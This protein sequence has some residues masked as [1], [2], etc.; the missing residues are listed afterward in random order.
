M[1]S[2]KTYTINNTKIRLVF[3]DILTSVT[4][5]LVISGSLGIPMKGGL[6][7][8]TLKRSGE[9]VLIDTAKFSNAKLGDVVVTSAGNLPHKYL[10]QAVT[11][12]GWQ[13]VF[14]HL[15]DAEN[16][17][18]HEYIIEHCIQNSLQLLSAMDLRSIA[19]P[20]LG[21]G[22]GN[23]S[24]NGVA[25]TMANVICQF[26]SKTNKSHE[27]Y[28]YI[29]DTYGVYEQ[30]N[31]LPFFEWFAAYVHEVETQY[32]KIDMKPDFEITAL[33]KIEIRDISSSTFTHRLFISYSRKDSDQAKGVCQ[34]LNSMGIDYWI[35]INGIYSGANFKE[36]IVRAIETSE[37]V[38]F[39]SSANSNTSPNV[40]K[41][42]ALA[43]KF[44]KVIIPV[45]LD[46]A[47]LNRQINYDLSTIDFVDLFTFDENSVSKLKKSI[48]GNLA[49][50]GIQQS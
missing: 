25:K 33:D 45:R 26:A 5:I 37:V 15:T 23:M 34:I 3:G 9:T 19:F 31:Y 43:D 40:A 4:D 17:E 12:S 29:K 10:F 50:N 11:V 32:V 7:E 8:A 21:L 16:T 46:N 14:P 20:C 44:N 39:L 1:N 22:M 27:I 2:I 47:P 48:L 30:F 6:P 13:N 35:D 18:V 38:L 49:M 24:L 28:I 42:I 41:E 36:Q